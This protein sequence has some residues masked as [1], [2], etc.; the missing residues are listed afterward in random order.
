MDG[1]M[2]QNPPNRPRR[3]TLSCQPQ[4]GF[5][6]HVNVNMHR[7]EL[8]LLGKGGGEDGGMARRY[9][10]RALLPGCAASV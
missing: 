7:D 9:T 5:L 3:T 6:P 2:K 8:S 1:W 10:L 4:V